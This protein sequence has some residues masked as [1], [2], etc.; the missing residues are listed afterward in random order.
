MINPSDPYLLEVENTKE[1]IL[2]A[3][4]VNLALGNG[5]TSLLRVDDESED[6]ICPMFIFSR[7]G[8]TD[9]WLTEKHNETIGS[10]FQKPE[11][12][13]KAIKCIDTLMLGKKDDYKLFKDALELIETE[14]N[15]KAFKLK[16]DDRKRSSM[17]A[18]IPYAIQLSEQWKTHLEEKG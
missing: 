6:E 10:F 3:C 4:I 5:Q 7:E 17:N 18:Y 14:E 13:K 15:K 11:L 12:V 2:S 1:G 8:D 16:W 9:K